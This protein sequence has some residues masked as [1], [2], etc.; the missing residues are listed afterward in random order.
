[1]YGNQKTR[2]EMTLWDVFLAVFR[3]RKKAIACFLLVMTATVF[4]TLLTPKAF[5]SES[6]LFVRLGRE[7]AMLDPAATLGNNPVVALPSSRESEINSVAEMLASRAIVEGVVDELGPEPILNGLA[8]ASS[9]ESANAR[10]FAQWLERAA[11]QVRE[12]VSDIKASLRSVLSSSQLSARDQAIEQLKEDLAVEPVRKSNVVCVTYEAPQPELAQ[13]VVRSVVEGYLAQ[14]V[15]M[16]RTRGTNEFFAEHTKR[17][18]DELKRLESELGELKT[19]TG[20]ASVDEQRTQIVTRIGRLEDEL[21]TTDTART[22]SEAEVSALRENLARLPKEQITETRT[23]LGNGGTDLIRDKFFALQ[24]QEKEASTLYTANHPKLQMIREE[25]SEAEQI[26]A[27]QEPTRTEVNTTPD[28]TYEQTRLALNLAEPQLAALN[29]KTELLKSQLTDVRGTLKM[30]N[31]NEIRIAQLT[32][33][34]EL[35]EADYRK[36]ATNL[37]QARI[38]HAMEAEQMSNISIVQPASLEPQAIRPRKAL[39]LALG[40]IVGVCGAFGVALLSE[41]IDHS[42]RT[43][44]EVVLKPDV[45][46]LPSTPRVSH[47][48]LGVD[49]RK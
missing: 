3:H 47:E 19:T 9:T 34:I 21:L 5:V 12:G 15:H 2:P 10:G 26:L 1:M 27:Q 18:G 43:P 44:K 13:R 4:V 29:A 48:A 20:L 7:N 41:Y 14:H 42:I 46:T 30:L 38:D 32:R 23:G 17:L 28:A 33:E 45:P 22:E 37:E 39:N 11:G 36:Y 40:L 24:V 8:E 49:A 31:T 6:K 25:L 35:H 16:N